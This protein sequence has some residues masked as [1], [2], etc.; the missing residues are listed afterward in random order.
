MPT[1]HTGDPTTD[2]PPDGFPYDGTAPVVEEPSDGD[3]LDA[4]SVE[5]MAQM[6][7]NRL[8]FEQQPFANFN[9][10][11]QPTKAFENA[12]HHVGAGFDSQA[13]PTG[14]YMQWEEDWLDVN[15]T[16]KT[17][18]GAGGAW[19]DRWNYRVRISGGSAGTRV[20]GDVG[21]PAVEPAGGVLRVDAGNVSDSP[22][23][24]H[25]AVVEACRAVHKLPDAY[26]AMEASFAVNSANGNN[27]PAWG[28]GA[29]D[30]VSGGS[31]DE[32]DT[33]GAI[34]NGAAYFA[35]SNGSGFWKCV[36]RTA[37]GSALS[38]TTAVAFA[39]NTVH[40]GR[41]AIYG[42]TSHPSATARVIF[43]IDGAEVANHAHSLVGVSLFP[44]ARSVAGNIGALGFILGPLR[45]TA[46][47][48]V[49]S[50][51]LI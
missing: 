14:R 4:A 35:H 41:I 24:T 13:L 36:S 42:A 15:A 29:G 12:L 25:L 31:Y 32:I 45:F 28:T 38:T 49:G 27:V 16:P 44:F 20:L 1:N 11:A 22:G 47:L 10:D 17:T 3:A 9:D 8:A 23:S 48:D 40:R 26:I 34:P 33:G 39:A 46:R 5:Q 43:Y 37:G 50:K 51:P 2:T 30:F 19:F 7:A 21:D 6:P 18:D